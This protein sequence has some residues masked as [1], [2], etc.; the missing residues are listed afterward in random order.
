VARRRRRYY[1]R[2]RVRLR[3]FR[4]E[5][6]SAAEAHGVGRHVKRLV[7]R[8]VSISGDY[9]AIGATGEEASLGTAH[10]GAVYIFVRSGSTWTEQQRLRAS[11]AL[12]YANFGVSVSL[13]GE[14]VLVGAERDY[15]SITDSGSAY[16]F[17]RT[18]ATWTQQAKLTASDEAA[19]DYFGFRVSLSGDKA[20]V[21][22]W[23]DDDAGSKSG[24][25]Y[26]FSR[27]GSTWT[28]QQK[29]TASDAAAGDV[30]SQSV[31]ISGD[32]ALI[33]S[34]GGTEATYVF[35]S[36][37]CDASIP[38]SNGNVGT[39]TSTLASGS[40][41]APACNS[42]YT[43]SRTS[44]CSAGTL[45]AATCNANSCDASTPPTNGAVGD[46]T[47]TLASGATCQPT[48]NSGYTFSGTSSCTAGT[49]TAAT[50]T[51]DSTSGTPSSPPPSGSS[52]NIAV[53]AGAA[54]GAFILGISVIAAFRYFRR[55]RGT[56][57][58]TA[59]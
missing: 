49:L 27:S 45:T 36:A 33:G 17:F 22:S 57:V 7:G 50:C 5:L 52:S 26:I 31:S 23:W 44:S 37:S 6:V 38:P 2:Q 39:C 40:T 53:I 28:Q 20:L 55:C 9:A 24:S 15:S 12:A 11:D 59:G 51:A 35:S 4:N 3:S 43:V 34:P 30:F 58:G 25:A 41:F 13:S 48:C 1:K 16:I 21:G 18:G 10:A 14:Y 56:A 29:L 32:Y 47:S 54:A 46:C 8:S 19:T 42:G